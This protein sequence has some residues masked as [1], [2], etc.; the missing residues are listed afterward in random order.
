MLPNLQQTAILKMERQ[1]QMTRPQRRRLQTQGPLS[2]KV[3]G[4]LLEDVIRTLG[5]YCLLPTL[6]VTLPAVSNY[7][8][9]ISSQVQDVYDFIYHL[10][11][12]SE[13]AEEFRTQEIDGQGLMFIKE[14]HII[15]ILHMKL[16]PALKIC[17]KIKDLK[18]AFNI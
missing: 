7:T 6:T 5:R 4:C 14:D 8:Y 1:L 3:Y 15:N 16:G 2:W 9:L 10:E 17:R 12:C 11:G 18:A 13:F